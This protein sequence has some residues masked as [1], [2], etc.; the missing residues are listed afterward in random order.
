MLKWKNDKNLSCCTVAFYV[1][2]K[3]ACPWNRWI[4]FQLNYM[5]RGIRGCCRPTSTATDTVQT[6]LPTR[7][8]KKKK[9][10]N[11]QS[12]YDVNG[13]D[14]TTFTRTHWNRIMQYIIYCNFSC[15]HWYH[16]RASCALIPASLQMASVRCD[17]VT[18]YLLAETLPSALCVHI[19]EI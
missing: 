19:L 17:K 4:Q 11:A 8:E 13:C 16:V 10:L 7:K 5:V 6:W 14:V 15:V 2:T 3:F 9:K 18:F 1:A 12:S